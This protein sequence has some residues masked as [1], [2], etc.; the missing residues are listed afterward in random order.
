M[1]KLRRR[2]NSSL[3]IELL[4]SWITPYHALKAR[5]GGNVYKE[6]S[7]RTEMPF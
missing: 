2:S 5:F 3:P 6:N 7:W 4:A 1:K